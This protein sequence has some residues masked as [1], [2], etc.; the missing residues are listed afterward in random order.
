M[1]SKEIFVKSFNGIGDA[2]F[3]SP[4]FRVIKDAYPD[5]KITFNTN[6]PGIF[7]NNPFIDKIGSKKNE[8]VFLS[9]SDPIHAKNPTE[10]HIISD[11][12]VICKA[13]SLVTRPPA[14]RPEIYLHLPK[15]Q[16]RGPILVQTQHKGHWHKKKVWPY[17]GRFASKL[18]YRKIPRCV[19][20][21]DLVYEIAEAR[22][23]VCSEGGISHI[24]KAVGTPAVV[25]YGGFA[26]PT[27]N[28]Y[29]NHKNITNV[30][31]CSYCYNPRRCIN[32]VEWRCMMEISI[33][34]V[35]EALVKYLE[36][37]DG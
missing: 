23:V 7:A 18:G 37:I 17:F 5:S 2:L 8:G 26:N 21:E 36:D 16:K 13:H 31:E 20:I 33:G 9:Y 10:H 6:Y 25:I 28:G 35:Q 1:R 4:S 15:R 3:A 19:S 32:E 27:W 11:W 30:K 29:N 22:C 14:L 24:A 12:R 34:Q